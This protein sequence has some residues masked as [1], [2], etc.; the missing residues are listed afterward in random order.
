MTKQPILNKDTDLSNI[1]GYKE[2]TEKS[3]LLEKKHFLRRF[4][5]IGS[6]FFNIFMVK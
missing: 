5:Y 1:K 4:P 6:S 2:Y 3:D